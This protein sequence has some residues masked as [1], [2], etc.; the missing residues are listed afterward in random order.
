LGRLE[1]QRIAEERL[2]QIRETMKATRPS[3]PDLG[4]LSTDP[5]EG[6]VLV[7]LGFGSR[8]GSQDQGNSFLR[9]LSQ[10]SEVVER[11]RVGYMGGKVVIPESTTL[12]L[13]GAD[14]EELF[15]AIEPVLAGQPIC[16]GANVTI[17][18]G[19]K[20]RCVLLPAVLN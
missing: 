10:V 15:R 11:E 12:M 3:D 13:Y 17:R 8:V 5:T 9:L 7:E 6:A 16:A 18:Q 1:A 14:G 2:A 19:S 20:H 4:A